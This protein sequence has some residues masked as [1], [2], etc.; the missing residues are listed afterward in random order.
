MAKH[1]YWEQLEHSYGYLYCPGWGGGT[2]VKET[3]GNLTDCKRRRKDRRSTDAKKAE[4]DRDS[5][6][7]VVKEK[8]KLK[9]RQKDRKIKR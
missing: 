4:K 9:G 1:N 5:E 8:R 3:S 6:K 7:E 2:P